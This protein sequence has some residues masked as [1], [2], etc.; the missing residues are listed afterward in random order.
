MQQDLRHVSLNEK[1]E[2]CTCGRVV[3]HVARKETVFRILGK[4]KFTEE[5]LKYLGD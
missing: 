2:I 1:N 5:F 4:E 3:Y